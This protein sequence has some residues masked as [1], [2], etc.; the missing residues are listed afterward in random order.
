MSAELPTLHVPSA[1]EQA[2]LEGCRLGGARSDV[3][4]QHHRSVL[5]GDRRIRYP[6]VA[7]QTSQEL[8]PARH[9]VA[10]RTVAG[11]LQV[12]FP[13]PARRSVAQGPAEQGGRSDLA[14][15]PDSTPPR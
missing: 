15:P 11:F 13:P 3:P 4:L 2:H 5:Y 6:L 9:A 7:L 8:G 1:L 10:Q 14:A 12:H